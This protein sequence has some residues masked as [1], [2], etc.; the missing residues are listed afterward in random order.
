MPLT[1]FDPSNS[2]A[3]VPP[4]RRRRLPDFLRETELAALFEAAWKVWQETS[5][6]TPKWKHARHRDYVMVMT[7]YYCGLRVRELCNLN[8]EDI[9]LEGEL[10]I[11]RHGKGDQDGAVPICAKL[12][13]VLKDWI[14]ERTSGVLFPDPR[15]RHV[16]T[17]HFRDRL[18]YF[19]KRA[20]IPRKCNPHQLRHSYC[21][22][23][24]RKGVSKGV[25]VFDVQRLMRH[26]DIKSTAF[27]LHLVPGK[28][29]EAVE[30]L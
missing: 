28:L 24:L 7:A 14:G 21:T 10:L 11:V 12:L 2:G 27:Y 5:D 6:A 8:V 22:H 30:L 3:S 4:K 29:K 20:A 23:L 1:L 26:R 9:D 16:H 13:T 19:A 18:Y 17:R 15:G 25:T